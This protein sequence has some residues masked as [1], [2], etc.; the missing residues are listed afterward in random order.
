MERCVLP[1]F[2]RNSLRLLLGLALASCFAVTALASETALMSVGQSPDAVM[3]R[4]ILKRM[5][6]ESDYNAMLQKSELGDQKVLIAVVGGSSKGLGAAGIDK[7]QEMARAREVFSEA[8]AKGMRVLIM[9]VGGE[10]RRGELTDF[11]VNDS[12]PFGEEI[13]V[14][15]G[16]NDDGIFDKLKGPDVSVSTA[17]KI[18]GVQEPL[19]VILKEWGVSGLD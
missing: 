6:V 12:V 14:V 10:G 17:D 11:F 16:G 13:I 7:E 8:K 1:V 5:K 2:L 4:V 15:K 9:H 19:A 18:Q 3:V